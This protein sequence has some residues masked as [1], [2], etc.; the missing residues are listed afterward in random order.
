[1]S[2]AAG[3][4]AS[5]RM[6][7]IMLA[8]ATLLSA[9][10]CTFVKMGPGAAQVSVV[11]QGRDVGGCE[12]RGEV[13]VSV[14]DRLGPYERNDMRVLDELETLARNEAPSLRADTIQPMAPPDDGEQR[15]LA[16]RC[17]GAAVQ[18]TQ[19]PEGAETVPLKD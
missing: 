15:F 13:E 11:A 16:F 19:A 3:P 8:A 14:K 12:K 4:L 10:A 1:M 5:S 18:P 2:L 17:A 7:L 9:S 6:R